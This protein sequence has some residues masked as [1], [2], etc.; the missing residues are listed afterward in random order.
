MLHLLAD[1]KGKLTVNDHAFDSVELAAKVF[2]DYQGG[3]VI[4]IDRKITEPKL[5]KVFVVRVRQYMTKPATPE[6]EFHKKWN[7]DV[8]M[9]MRVMV[10]S[11]VQETKGMFKMSLHGDITQ[12]IT[13]CC[14]VCGRPLSNPVSKYFGIGPECGNHGYVNPFETEEELR[15]AVSQ[16]RQKL[17][18]VKWE[19]WIIKSAIESMEEIE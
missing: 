16:Y 1:Y 12:K 8:P 6:F 10:G 7:N 17:N 5:S 13:E 11:I 19:G 18:D 2:A 9:P 15:N 14:M 3:L 4:K